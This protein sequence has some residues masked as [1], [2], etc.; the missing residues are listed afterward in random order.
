MR[1]MNGTGPISRLEFCFGDSEYQPDDIE[2][3]LSS[4]IHRSIEC[5]PSFRL[6]RASLAQL[7]NRW[8]RMLWSL[9]SK[10]C[11]GAVSPWEDVVLE[12]LGDISVHRAQSSGERGNIA[13]MRVI[14]ARTFGASF[15][16]E[17]NHRFAQ[18]GE[19]REPFSCTHRVC[20]LHVLLRVRWVACDFLRYGCR[21]HHWSRY[22]ALSFHHHPRRGGM[23]GS[24]QAHARSA[25]SKRGLCCGRRKPAC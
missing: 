14:A 3:F 11:A 17:M 1:H 13:L 9:M 6:R 12:S 22:V 21:Y 25:R 2:L 4:R 20:L 7:R 24:M 18:V 8:F 15:P 10:L 5:G 23:H 16:T 19:R